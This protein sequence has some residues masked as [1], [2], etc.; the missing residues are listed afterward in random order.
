MSGIHQRRQAMAD[1]GWQSNWQDGHESERTGMDRQSVIN[2]YFE[3]NLGNL[4]RI[5]A[6]FF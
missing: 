1:G 6:I 3:A 4:K 2:E 5:T